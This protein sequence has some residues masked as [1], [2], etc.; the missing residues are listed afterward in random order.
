MIKKVMMLIQD[1]INLTISGLYFLVPRQ[2]NLWIFGAWI[3]EA[4]ADNS[5]YL[6]EFVCKHHPEI[7]AIWL[8]QEDPVYDLVYEKGYKVSMSNTLK[9][10]WL[11]MR[12]YVS[13][14]SAGCQDL[15]NCLDPKIKRVYLSHG[16]PLKKIFYDIEQKN[17][18][19]DSS[20]F[21][22]LYR[23]IFRK[24]KKDTEFK[25]SMFP[26]TSEESRKKISSGF[27]AP[28]E[29]VEITG[30]PRNDAFFQEVNQHVPMIK[31][32]FDLKKEGKNIAIYMPTFRAWNKFDPN[33]LQLSNLQYI[34]DYLENINT[35]LLLKLHHGEI[36]QLDT[37]NLSIYPNIIPVTQ[38]SIKYDI[39]PIMKLTD[40]L[41]TDYSGVYFDYL[42]LN[43]PIIFA[44]FD[45][46]NY[47]KTIKTLYYRYDDVTPGPKAI[48]WEEVM[49]HLSD[50]SEGVDEYKAQRQAMNDR[51]NIYKDGNN[52]QRVFDKIIEKYI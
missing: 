35:I 24:K 44:P 27:R 39:Y 41:I 16:T 10:K 12:A 37:L 17:Y 25:N 5:K 51:F 50:I 7:D 26:A 1:I 2:K 52:S 46:E 9:G 32:I 49:N 6:F 31:K 21:Q 33:R 11:A 28:I 23:K 14:T 13:V 45:I 22:E 8:T 43:K 19:E 3:G 48:S 38:E 20:Y 30:Y 36:K 34:N 40:A 4:Y 15:D 29:H 47:Q 42:I 18:L